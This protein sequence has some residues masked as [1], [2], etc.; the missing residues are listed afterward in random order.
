MLDGKK[1]GDQKDPIG[2]GILAADLIRDA[3]ESDPPRMQN[4]RRLLGSLKDKS[5]NLAFS[6][7]ER[8]VFHSERTTPSEE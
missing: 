1:Y 4:N 8:A 3:F 7:I 5:L 2:C 6:G